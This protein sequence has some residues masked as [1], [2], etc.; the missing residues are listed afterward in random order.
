[1]TWQAPQGQQYTHIEVEANANCPM[2]AN[3]VFKNLTAPLPVE[4]VRLFEGEP[5]GRL[6]SVTGW[7]SDGDGSP[8]PAFAA[9][10]EDSSAGSA[11]VVYGGDWGVRLRPHDSAAAWSISDTEQWGETHLVLADQDDIVLARES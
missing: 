4:A 1:M 5:E 8:C 7:S 11:F 6:F 3:N 2:S 10:V 9:R